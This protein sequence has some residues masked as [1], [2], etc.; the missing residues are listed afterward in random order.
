MPKKFEKKFISFC[1]NQDL[2]VNH[3]QITVIKK[4][5]YYH[6]NNYKSFFT[7]LFSKQISKKGFYLYGGVGVGKTMILN[8]F[9]DLL[10]EK[11][12]KQHF[13]ELI[14]YIFFFFFFSFMNKIMET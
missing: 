5:E 14:N 4:L 13:N 7:K 1:E 11:K 8:F 2:E 9:Y 10:D 3:N 6:H 12:M